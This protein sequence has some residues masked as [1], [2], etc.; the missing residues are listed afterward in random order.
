MKQI[1][2]Y[3]QSDFDYYEA[4]VGLRL[5]PFLILLLVVEIIG[6]VN[7]FSFEILRKCF[8]AVER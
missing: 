1:L 3:S 4:H 6:I 7:N 5:T 8:V 2:L